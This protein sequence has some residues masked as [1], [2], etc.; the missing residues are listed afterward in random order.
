MNQLPSDFLAEAAALEDAYL[1]SADPIRQS[2]FGGGPERWRAERSPILDAVTRDGHLLDI[3]CA[4]GYLAECLVRWVAER[5]ITLTP[6]GIDIGPKLIA[7]AK[8]RLPA[9]AANFHVANGWDWQ[10]D[11][12]FGYVYTLSDVVPPDMLAEY[13]GR[14]LERL[15]E[16]GGRLI[17]GSY[18]SRSRS[19]PPLPIGEMLAS[20]GHTVAGRSWGGDPPITAFAWVVR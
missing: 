13:V 8:R 15:V 10:P 16:P 14:L 1:Q 4:N 18:G 12:R 19:T 17:V 6:H 2:G 5:G 20:Y 7:E 3:G 9:F 11:R